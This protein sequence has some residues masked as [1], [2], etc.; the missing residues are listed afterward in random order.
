MKTLPAVLLALAV[1]AVRVPA[2]TNTVATNEPPEWKLIRHILAERNEARFLSSDIEV[3]RGR[4][5]KFRIFPADYAAWLRKIKTDGLP[6]HFRI[7]WNNYVEAWHEKSKGNPNAFADLVKMGSGEPV[8]FF[9][10]L[11]DLAKNADAGDSVHT[12]WVAVE[13]ASLEVGLDISPH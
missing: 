5:V 9:S 10:G 11:A 1:M 4:V 2:Q 3:Q 6:A 13:D 8:M 12:A 7:A